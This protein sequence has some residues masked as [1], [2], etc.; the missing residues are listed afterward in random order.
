MFPVSRAGSTVWL[1]V[2]IANYKSRKVCDGRRFPRNRPF[3][4]DKDHLAFPDRASM[5]WEIPHGIEDHYPE[6]SCS[7]GRNRLIE[8]DRGITT[9]MDAERP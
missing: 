8:L 9:L 6:G 1:Y 5:T 2:H 4:P 7:C 3:A